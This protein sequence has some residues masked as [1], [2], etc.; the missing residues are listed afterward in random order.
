M[1]HNIE[2]VIHRQSSV[3]TFSQ[4]TIQNVV[5]P[6][7]GMEGK[8]EASIAEQDQCTPKIQLSALCR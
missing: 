8:S 6:G 2:R 1:P 4:S 3:K 7:L 5:T